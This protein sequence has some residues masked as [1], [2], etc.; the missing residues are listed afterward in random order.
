MPNTETHWNNFYEYVK[1]A[2]PLNNI[3]EGYFEKCNI[4]DGIEYVA[5]K[6]HHTPSICKSNYID[7]KLV[8]KYERNPEKFCEYFKGNV[9]KKFTLH[10]SENY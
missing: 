3:N 2:L 8:E 10:L 7:P 5:K 6:L 4:K 9:N 1:K